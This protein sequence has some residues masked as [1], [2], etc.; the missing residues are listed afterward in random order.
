MPGASLS[1]AATCSPRNVKCAGSRK[2]EVWLTV[3]RS[4]RSWAPQPV[5]LDLEHLLVELGEAGESLDLETGAEPGLE[6][7]H[8]VGLEGDAD[9][10]AQERR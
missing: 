9:L 1:Q 10:V 6:Q 5:G 7:T 3:L 8:A 4:I 2:N